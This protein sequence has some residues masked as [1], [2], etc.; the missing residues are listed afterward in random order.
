MG[1]DKVTAMTSGSE[2]TDA[3]CKVA[4][5]WGVRVKGIDPNDVLILGTS[6][7]FHGFISGVWP[8][9]APAA[10]WMGA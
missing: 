10:G 9:M 4:R 2:A 7:N 5:G 1:Y 8:L 3:A 6:E